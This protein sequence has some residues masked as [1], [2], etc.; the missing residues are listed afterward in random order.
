MGLR[1]SVL[2]PAGVAGVIEGVVLFLAADAGVAIDAALFSLTDVGVEG[3]G[4]LVPLVPFFT[5][6]TLPFLSPLQTTPPSSSSSLS[7]ITRFRFD[8]DLR[9]GESAKDSFTPSPFAFPLV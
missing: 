6:A 3:S 2:L 9:I 1:P 4:M 7:I 8:F 5:S